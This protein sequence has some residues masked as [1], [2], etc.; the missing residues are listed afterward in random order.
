[1]KIRKYRDSLKVEDRWI[2]IDSWKS[3][4]FFIF[5]CHE[6]GKFYLSYTQKEKLFNKYNDGGYFVTI[7]EPGRETENQVGIQCINYVHTVRF[8]KPYR[9]PVL[10]MYKISVRFYEMG[11]ISV[12]NSVLAKVVTILDSG[13]G[14]RTGGPGILV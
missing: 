7:F 4:L 12:K 5:L 9:N 11:D 8:I 10:Q 6:I 13:R 14:W 3:F 2:S 1:M